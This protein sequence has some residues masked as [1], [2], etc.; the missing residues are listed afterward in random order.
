MVTAYLVIFCDY[1]V[2]SVVDLKKSGIDSDFLVVY[3][4]LYICIGALSCGGVCD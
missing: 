2:E 3:F 4:L 1:V